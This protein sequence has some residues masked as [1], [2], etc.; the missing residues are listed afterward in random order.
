MGSAFGTRQR[1]VRT[2]HEKNY[3]KRPDEMEAGRSQ[4][5]YINRL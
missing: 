5:C 1:R 4:I 3:H 2:K